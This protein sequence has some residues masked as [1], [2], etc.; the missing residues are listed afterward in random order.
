M[1]KTGLLVVLFVFFQY[2]A[3]HSQTLVTQVTG[4]VI[5]IGAPICEKLGTDYAACKGRWQN[6]NGSESAT[7]GMQARS[8]YGTVS[9]GSTA[10]S[11][12]SGFCQLATEAQATSWAGDVAYLQ[13]V[14]DSDAYF[15][16][17]ISA[18][19]QVTDST[20][21][22]AQVLMQIQDEEGQRA[23][24]SV[25]EA[26]GKCYA[27]IPVTSSTGSV[28]FGLSAGAEAFASLNSP[29]GGSLT[30]SASCNGSITALA[31]VNSKGQ[32]LKNVVITTGSGHT[33]PL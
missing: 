14:P 24:C 1:S 23:V 10:V 13:N 30:E 12:C 22:P 9:G 4:S 26:T 29:T 27:Y 33:Y 3:A 7:V 11:D 2:V 16:V 20:A 6:S 8:A 25:S 31:V 15:L 28:T 21:D 32:V 5:G 17:K 18:M 19:I